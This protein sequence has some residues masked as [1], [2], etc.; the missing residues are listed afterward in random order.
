MHKTMTSLPTVT[1]PTVRRCS[2]AEAEQDTLNT[3][4]Q[5]IKM[6]W[7][8]LQGVGPQ[9]LLRT[10]LLPIPI[11]FFCECIWLSA[12]RTYISRIAEDTYGPNLVSLFRVTCWAYGDF[13]KWLLWIFLPIIGVFFCIIYFNIIL[14]HFPGS[15]VRL[16]V[17]ISGNYMEKICS[18]HLFI[19][20]IGVKKYL[21]G[22]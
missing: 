20:F 16:P 13:F 19:Y 4:E 11:I 12:C 10:L 17:S 21:Q 1:Q 7:S 22:V 8:R 9:L 18:I 15:N 14:S 5:E 2:M 3:T 6:S